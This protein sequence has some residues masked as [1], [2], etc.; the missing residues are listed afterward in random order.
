MPNSAARLTF[1]V[2]STRQGCSQQVIVGEMQRRNPRAMDS[3]ASLL[4]GTLGLG[5][6]RLLWF[7]DLDVSGKRVIIAKRARVRQ[8]KKER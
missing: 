1:L 3:S 2:P 4:A 8:A 6:V 5:V 7:D